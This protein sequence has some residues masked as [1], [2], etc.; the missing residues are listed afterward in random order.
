M[1]NS[2]KTARIV[3]G[4]LLLLLVIGYF[5]LN[6]MMDYQMNHDHSKGWGGFG[7]F[8]FIHEIY[9]PAMVIQGILF[10][11]SLLIKEK[12]KIQSIIIV[13]LSIALAIAMICF[14][15]L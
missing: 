2:H 5:G 13:F 3:S 4:A 15:S 12:H 6:G 8:L 7:T 11:G 9:I 14:L 1:N 10:L